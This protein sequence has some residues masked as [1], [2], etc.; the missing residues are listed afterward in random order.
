MHRKLPGHDGAIDV[1]MRSTRMC[2]IGYHVKVNKRVF[3]KM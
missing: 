1:Q 2:Y 3:K